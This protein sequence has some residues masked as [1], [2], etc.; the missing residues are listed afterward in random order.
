MQ[1][2]VRALAH[3][4][5]EVVGVDVAAR[6][7]EN[8]TLDVGP[9]YAEGAGGDLGLAVPQLVLGADLVT[10]DRVGLIGRRRISNANGAQV[11]LADRIAGV[12]GVTTANAVPPWPLW[13]IPCC[14]ESGY[15]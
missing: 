6:G 7:Q 12:R 14:Q 15:M 10:P 8:E 9:V 4:G 3:R 5:A 1:V 2:D 11:D 13:R